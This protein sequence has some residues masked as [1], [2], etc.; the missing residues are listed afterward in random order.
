MNGL[1]KSVMVGDKEVTV[2]ELSVNE[3][4]NWM[5]E[6]ETAAERDDLIIGL[7]DVLFDDVRL[8]DLAVMSDQ[9][10]ED[11]REMFPS[12]LRAIA[13][14]CREV[15]EHFFSAAERVMPALQQATKELTEASSKLSSAA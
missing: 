8:S 1:T 14:A 15:N 7:D 2:R 11:L 12:Q 9:S 13:D 10:V 6:T 5:A 3:V 4:R